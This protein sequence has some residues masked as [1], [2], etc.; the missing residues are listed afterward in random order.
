MQITRIIVPAVLLCLTAT[1]AAFADTATEAS[2]TA[3]A[4]EVEP[5]PHGSRRAYIALGAG[6]ALGDHGDRAAG[7][8]PRFFSVDDMDTASGSISLRAGYRFCPHLAAELLWDYQTGW[9]FQT[10]DIHS[11]GLRDASITAWN[12]MANAKGYLTDGRWQPFVVVGLGVGRR[13]TDGKSQYFDPERGLTVPVHQVNT[14]F[15]ARFGGGLDVELSEYWTF[16][17]EVV[18]VLGNGSLDDLDYAITSVV[19]TYRFL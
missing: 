10:P 6:A 11:M 18:W 16:G 8:A 4:S 9:D 19:L 17:G 2:T 13:E 1:S 7:H 5:V 14:D 15:V 12:L 3:T